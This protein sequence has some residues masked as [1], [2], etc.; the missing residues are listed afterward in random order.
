MIATILL[1]AALFLAYA[2]GAND[3]FK[4]VATLFGSGTTTFNRALAWATVTTF[5]GSAA[6]LIL[7]N[8]LLATFSGKGLV[9]DSIIGEPAFVA[10]IALGS[11]A[12]VMLATRL[13]FPVSTTHALTGALVGAGL[14]VS[15]SGVEFSK[16][17]S[18]FAIPLL[19][20]PLIAIICAS[21]LYPAARWLRRRCGVTSQ[22][23]L[24]LGSEVVQILPAHYRPGDAV[25][26]AS[27]VQVPGISV[28]ESPSC[29]V[30]YDGRVL[31]IEARPF[32]D[33][34]HYVSAGLVSFARGLNDTP[35]IV[36]LLLL[37]QSLSPQFGFFMVA[38]A[39]AVGGLISSNRVA[40]TMSHK[41]T[42]MNAGQGFIANAVT[43]GLVI[44]ASKL[45]VP[46]STTHVSCGALFGIGAVTGQAQ[47]K[48]IANILLA[49]VTTLPVAMVLSALFSYILRIHLP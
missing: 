20:S 25:A 28:G 24:C 34:L 3:N 26:L 13:S 49:W 47:G 29:R 16:L 12:T 11:A 42:A 45:G 22:S 39:V 48:M 14:V 4:G 10:A 40:E 9:P 15:P 43:A 35:K 1:F 19:C 17:L 30:L 18:S 36:A 31:G 46:V 6:S 32:L 38:I 23:C 8:G 7:A 27:L 21:S 41:I 44:F 2:N 37:T 5:L 33:V